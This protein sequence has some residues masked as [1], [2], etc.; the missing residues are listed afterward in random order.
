MQRTEDLGYATV[1]QQKNSL[2]TPVTKA[3][4]IRIGQEI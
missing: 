2:T 4:E 1:L 3:E